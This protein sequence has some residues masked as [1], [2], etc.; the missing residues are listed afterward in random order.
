MFDREAAEREEERDPISLLAFTFSDLAVLSTLSFSL[1][2][3]DHTFPSLNVLLVGVDPHGPSE[4]SRHQRPREG[5]HCFFLA[6]F[7]L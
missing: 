2:L 4:T 5:S 3:S 6:R 1:S 7:L